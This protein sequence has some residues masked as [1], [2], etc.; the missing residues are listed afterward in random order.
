MKNC[1]PWEGL[2]LDKF[3]E[4]CLKPRDPTLEKGKS[5][6]NPPHKEEGVAMCDELR[7]IPHP[8]ALP[9]G[10]IKQKPGVKFSLGGREGGE[11]VFADFVFISPYLSYSDLIEKKLNSFFQ[12]VLPMI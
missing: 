12:S 3:R 10:R 4:S 11:K 7:A 6:R 2:T 8:P 1:S 5:V 9:G